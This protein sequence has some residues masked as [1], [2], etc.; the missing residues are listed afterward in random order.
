[1]LSYVEEVISK[2]DNPLED[3]EEFEMLQPNED[4]VND[5][6]YL[7]FSENNDFPVDDGTLIHGYVL[8][9]K[10]WSIYVVTLIIHLDYTAKSRKIA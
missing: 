9:I 5:T 1:M 2:L 4:R 8:D 3:F 7:M 10:E 6:I